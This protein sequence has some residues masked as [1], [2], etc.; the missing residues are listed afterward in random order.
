MQFWIFSTGGQI[1]LLRVSTIH[2][3]FDW[4]FRVASC[5]RRGV[6]VVHVQDFGDSQIMFGVLTYVISYASVVYDY[7]IS[8]PAGLGKCTFPSR[9]DFG[10]ATGATIRSFPRI[11]E[12]FLVRFSR[13]CP[14]GGRFYLIHV[15]KARAIRIF[16]QWYTTRL[17][18]LTV[19][20]SLAAAASCWYS[21]LAIFWHMSGFSL[22]I[23]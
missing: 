8:P 10:L 5:H 11:L 12:C 9:W 1:H 18:V 13:Q 20:N 22:S 17:V 16:S 14:G 21:M 3:S 23:S 19:V 4:K 7:A 15:W 6:T 2:D